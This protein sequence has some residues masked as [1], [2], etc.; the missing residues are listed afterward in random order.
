MLHQ[1]VSV[2]IKE[3]II[4]FLLKVISQHIGALLRHLG[5]LFVLKLKIPI[6]LSFW[7]WDYSHVELYLFHR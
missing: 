1:I 5:V 7:Y 3:H 4:N 2:L 6:T